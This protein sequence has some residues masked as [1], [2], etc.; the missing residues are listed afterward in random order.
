[1]VFEKQTGC[2][3]NIHIIKPFLYFFFEQAIFFTFNKQQAKGL[4]TQSI[5]VERFGKRKTL[6]RDN[7]EMQ[8]KTRDRLCLPKFATHHDQET[9]L[10]RTL[11]LVKYNVHGFHLNP[12]TICEMNESCS[13]KLAEAAVTN[14]TEDRTGTMLILNNK[15]SK[16]QTPGKV[17]AKSSPG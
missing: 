7:L 12:K 1:M 16:I 9:K 13:K 2:Y 4:V 17:P 10:V 14:K 15:Q 11:C 5:D 8:Y 6:N 3:C